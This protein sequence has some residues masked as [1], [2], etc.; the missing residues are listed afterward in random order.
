MWLPSAARLPGAARAAHALR[1]ARAGRAAAAPAACMRVHRR[2]LLSGGSAPDVPSSAPI[3]PLPG[4][5]RA[6]PRWEGIPW[7]AQSY[8]G[9]S[10]ARWAA[11]RE[12]RLAEFGHTK[13]WK[14]LSVEEAM[15]GYLVRR[16]DL[17]PYPH[18]AKYNVY[19]VPRLTRFYIVFDVQD[20]ALKRWGSAAALREALAKRESKR[21]RRIARLQPPVL[22]LLRPVRTRKG[23]VVVGARAVGAAILGNCGVVAAKMLGWSVSGSASL[24][25]E[26]I[27]SL[28][29]LGNQ[30]MLAVGLR[31][32][33]RRA[34]ATRPYGYG[35]E[36][37]VWAMISGVSTFILG[38]GAS[39]Y[40]GVSLLYNPHTP[41]SLPT[42]F[43]VIR[44]AITP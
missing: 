34:D 11:G 20:A 41:E 39:T 30:C 21:E 38:A 2:P 25:S 35:F 8:E 4:P 16:S 44:A 37:Y 43:A 14:T 28:A 9:G 15:S 3:G 13:Q 33:L 1:G 23:H 27:H 36:Q 12:R 40:H 7:L 22:M 24:L 10:A 6:L 42:A 32:S 31:Q 5:L 29:D 18:V 17:Q 26:A 19:G